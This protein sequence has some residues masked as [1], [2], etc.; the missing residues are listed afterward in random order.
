V[1]QFRQML[2]IA[3][4]AATSL[5]C[6]VLHAQ[7]SFSYQTYALKNTPQFVVSGDLNGDGKPDLVVSSQNGN[8]LSV[9]LNNGNGRFA[10]EL[11]LNPIPNFFTAL[12]V[13]DFNGDKKLDILA[14]DTG[15]LN[16]GTAPGL[17]VLLGNGDGTLQA[18]VSTSLGSLNAIIAF[19]GVGDF[20]GDGK[21]DVALYA[22]DGTNFGPI[23]LSS[24]GDGTFNTGN[25]VPAPATLSLVAAVVT[26]ANADGELDLILSYI[27]DANQQGTILTSLGNGHGTFQPPTQALP[28]QDFWMFTLTTGDFRHRNH[29][30]LVSTSYQEESCPFGVC[31]PTGPAGTVAILPATANSTFGA[32]GVL[33]SGDYGQLATGDFDGDGNIDIAVFG[34]SIHGF[35]PPASVIMLGDGKSGFPGQ[36]PTSFISPIAAISA[37]LTGDGLSDLAVIDS[38]TLEVALNTTPGFSLSTS[39]AGTPIPP[40]GLATY[41]INIGQQNGFNGTVSLTCSAPASQGVTC[42]VSPSSATPGTASSLTVATTG[43]SGALVRSGL[44]GE[45]LY[46]VWFP[47]GALVFGSIGV[48]SGKKRRGLLFCLVFLVGCGGAS[49][50]TNVRGTPSGNY[51]IVVTGSSGALQRSTTVT[52]KVN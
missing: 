31:R 44:R 38:N 42:S 40:G 12:A 35:T 22:Y 21:T 14:L 1:F 5:E 13:G 29:N 19:I 52:L 47:V 10:P 11:D 49:N 27:D 43:V 39:G 48:R 45:W 50:S 34:R 32:P 33:M 26:D 4:L 9:L 6:A 8:I 15:N 37:D 51:T 25:L 28:P 30:D 3:F 7:V 18:P 16:A 36:V 17:Y 2:T 41:T 46:A 20:N 24:N 23:A